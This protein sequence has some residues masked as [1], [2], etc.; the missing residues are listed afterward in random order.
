MAMFDGWLAL[1]GLAEEA[2][3]ARR[4]GARVVIGAA[5]PTLLAERLSQAL[6]DPALRPPGLLS[7]GLCGGLTPDLPAGILVIGTE[8]RV[9]GEAIA[10][11][12]AYRDRLRA[13]LPAAHAAVVV[14][15]D[16]IAATAADKAALRPKAAPTAIVDMES[17]AAA[18]TACRL[19]VPFVVLR[20]VSDPAEAG[21]PPA[22]LLALT[23]GGRPRPS[24]VL[25]SLARRPAQLPALIR[26]GRDTARAFAA[27][28]GILTHLPS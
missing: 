9:G 25:A 13:I 28:R 21:L 7:F 4:L 23:P 8:V 5:D 2:A 27:L 18:L 26:L 11:D 12:A 1:V 19:G 22:A 15:S 14:S 17:G 16:R 20:A 10:T 3:I 24:S 6:A